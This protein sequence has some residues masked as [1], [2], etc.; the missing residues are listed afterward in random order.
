M[1]N[2]P[3]DRG[4]ETYMTCKTHKTYADAQAAVATLTRLAIRSEMLQSWPRR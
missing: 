2:P 1:T 3:F 4:H